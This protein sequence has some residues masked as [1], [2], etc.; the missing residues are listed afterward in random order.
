MCNT[1]FSE[2]E[3]K[4]QIE[5]Q[6]EE[7][8]LRT[9]QIS[10]E[11]SPELLNHSEDIEV[12]RHENTLPVETTMY[13]EGSKE[14]TAIG[15]NISA[16]EAE[17]NHSK[18]NEN[19]EIIFLPQLKDLARFVKAPERMN[20]ADELEESVENFKKASEQYKKQEGIPITYRQKDSKENS[21]TPTINA[22]DTSRSFKTEKRKSA[23]EVMSKVKTPLL[24]NLLA[25]NSLEENSVYK[26]AMRFLQTYPTECA[27]NNVTEA[28]AKG[29]GKT[30][31]KVTP[32]VH[33]NL[34]RDGIKSQQNIVPELNSSI[35]EMENL[36]AEA[37][38]NEVC[39][40]ILICT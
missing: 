4:A 33:S 21:H 13:S 27:Q 25:G 15:T 12:F 1:C 35:K 11:E 22:P 29:L 5:R 16:H 40:H 32:T 14:R 7:V 26:R 3:G 24:H 9:S 36:T 6:I 19:S 39:C 17:L 34:S 28:R 38:S 31:L 8:S 20:M 23:D 30:E 10:I 2:E 37:A 18:I